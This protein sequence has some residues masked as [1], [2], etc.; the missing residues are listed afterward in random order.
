MIGRRTAAADAIRCACTS[1][2]ATCAEPFGNHSRFQVLTRT[3]AG[4]GDSPATP[5]TT[6]DPSKAKKR[7][8]HG[9]T[10]YQS[11]SLA[12]KVFRLATIRVLLGFQ[13]SSRLITGTKRDNLSKSA[14][15]WGG[16]SA[17]ISEGRII[18]AI[19]QHITL[20]FKRDLAVRRE[21]NLV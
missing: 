2:V 18:W 20:R 4:S 21:V 14:W 12:R 3:F 10:S 11:I 1:G 13:P 17:V 7:T 19:C 15:S 8:L 6:N 16:V 9:T 5:A